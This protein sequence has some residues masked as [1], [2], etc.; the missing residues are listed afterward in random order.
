MTLKNKVSG[1]SFRIKMGSILPFEVAK[2]K[3]VNGS[4]LTLEAIE[5]PHE[6]CY[7]IWPYFADQDYTIEGTDN[8]TVETE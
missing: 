4:Y 3:D 2:A 1:R 5:E 7:Y 8:D 6:E